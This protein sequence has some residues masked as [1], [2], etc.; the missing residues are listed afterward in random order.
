MESIT[1]LG[2]GSW[3][4]ALAA[5]WGKDD[6]K[7]RLWARDKSLAER[8][9]TTRENREYLPGVVLPKSVKETTELGDAVDVDLIVFVTP[10]MALRTIA[11]NLANIGVKKET[12][13]LS[14]TKGI[15]HGTG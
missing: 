12:M 5:L 13:L 6:R 14:C 1:I 8:L 2:A 11:Q 9:Q 3:G 4:T 7:L 10:S 15:E